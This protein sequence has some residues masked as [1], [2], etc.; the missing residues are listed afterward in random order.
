[1]KKNKG[2]QDFCAYQP[3]IDK[4]SFVFALADGAS[5]ARFAQIGAMNNV[6]SFINFFKKYSTE[7]ILQ[8]RDSFNAAD[9]ISASRM[10]QQHSIH[11]LG[12]KDFDLSATLIGCVVTEKEIAVF[13]IGDG[14]VYAKKS[15]GTIYTVSEPENVFGQRNVTRFTVSDNA[16]KYVRITHVDRK[17]ISALFITSDGLFN[18]RKDKDVEH[19]ISEILY[20]I[21]LDEM[22][23]LTF[24]AM[25][26]EE[27]RKNE[28]DDCS[29]II[30]DLQ[31]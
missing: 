21:S 31:N 23:N 5:S 4:D 25:I 9:I 6:F 14:A 8:I 2:C 20:K 3:C 15:D 17:E 13:H 11:D 22:N 18:G 28:G 7:E 12:A 29:A 19:F 16:E 27:M 24:T 10:Y 1:M 30:I 26:D